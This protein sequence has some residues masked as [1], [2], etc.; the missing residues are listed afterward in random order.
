MGTFVLVVILLGALA[1]GGYYLYITKL[2]TARAHI[3]MHWLALKTRVLMRYEI[4]KWDFTRR[5]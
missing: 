4:A 3:E 5:R 1:L 2:P